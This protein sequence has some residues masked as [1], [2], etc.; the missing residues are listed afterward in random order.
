MVMQKDSRLLPN[1]TMALLEGSKDLAVEGTIRN[2]VLPPPAANIKKVINDTATHRETLA[3]QDSR[4]GFECN[5]TTTD[6]PPAFE[7]EMVTELED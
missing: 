5:D 7:D 1:R 3:G 2:L 4:K 6:K